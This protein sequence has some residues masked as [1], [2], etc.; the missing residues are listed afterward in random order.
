[1]AGSA[2]P[3]QYVVVRDYTLYPPEAQEWA[4]RKGISQPPAAYS[5]LCPPENGLVALHNSTAGPLD[6]LHSPDPS[7]QSEGCLILSS[8]DLGAIYRIVKGMPLTHQK[9]KVTL[10]AACNTQLKTVTM[11]VDGEPFADLTA[12]PFEAFWTLSPGSHSFSATALDGSGNT[13][14]SN[15]VSIMVY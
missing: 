14:S 8:P 5:P 10:Y 6:R 1:L 13:L 3:E 2:C 9:I 7:R 12:P 11:L 15:D 4:R